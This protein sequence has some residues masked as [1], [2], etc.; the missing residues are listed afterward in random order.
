MIGKKMVGI[1]AVLTALVLV[2][3]ACTPVAGE[4]IEKNHIPRDMQM[5]P[6]TTCV[7]NGA[8]GT[9][10]RTALRPQVK[11]ECWQIKVRTQKENVR[12]RCI[13]KSDWE[14]IEIGSQYSSKSR[15]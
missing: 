11:P 5:I 8:G 7:S 12:T 15:G 3:S 13:K 9:T 6:Y 10:C 4:V 14:Q 1:V 2:L